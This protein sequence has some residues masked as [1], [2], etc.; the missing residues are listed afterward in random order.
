MRSARDRTAHRRRSF[1]RSPPLIFALDC[2]HAAADYD[3]IYLRPFLILEAQQRG[4][5]HEHILIAVPE[6][7]KAKR[8]ASVRSQQRLRSRC[9]DLVMQLSDARAKIREL[10]N[11][12]DALSS[13][14]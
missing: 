1:S 10:E 13:E 12:I 9:I 6:E 11:T 5:A 4:H 3:F 7:W 8:A 14:A 2:S